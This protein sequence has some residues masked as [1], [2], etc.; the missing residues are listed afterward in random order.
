MWCSHPNFGP[1]EVDYFGNCVVTMLGITLD[2]E[3]NKS[4]RK[5][6]I[7]KT[8]VSRVIPSGP[9]NRRILYKKLFGKLGQTKQ[10]FIKAAS[11]VFFPI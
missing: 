6:S 11:L 5:K 7:K 9:E 4:K 2:T 10:I 3:S 8:R 1:S